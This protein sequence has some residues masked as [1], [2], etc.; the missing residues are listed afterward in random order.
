MLVSIMIPFYF[1]REGGPLRWHQSPPVE[2]S[3]ARQAGGQVSLFGITSLAIFVWPTVILL[4]LLCRSLRHGR[5]WDRKCG[6]PEQ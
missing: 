6:R 4:H 3:E 1:V 5:H 2:V